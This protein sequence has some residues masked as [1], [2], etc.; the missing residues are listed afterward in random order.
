MT[1]TQL[2]TDIRAGNMLAFKEFVQRYEGRIAT[3]IHGMIGSVAEADDIGQ[4]VF[5]RFYRNIANFRGD[6]S[7]LTYLTRIAI[8]LSINEIKRRKRRSL[9]F[10]NRGLDEQIDNMADEVVDDEKVFREKIVHLAIQKL[11]EKHRSV[12]VLRIIEGH[13]TEQTA[14]ILG[15]PTG[16]VLS[17]LARGQ[18]KLKKILEPYLEEV[19]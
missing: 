17:R 5:I 6:A 9:L 3:T 18:D 8:N 15:V 14:H 10:I 4:E 11:D 16:T 19:A 13:S 12:V 1:D 7:P 2:I